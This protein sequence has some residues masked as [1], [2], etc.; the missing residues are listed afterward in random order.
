MALN[1][2]TLPCFVSTPGSLFVKG[3]NFM[4]MH[5]MRG[6][7][8]MGDKGNHCLS[9]IVYDWSQQDRWLHGY[10]FGC[11]SILLYH[12]IYFKGLFTLSACPHTPGTSTG[13]ALNYL[14]TL[15]KYSRNLYISGLNHDIEYHIFIHIKL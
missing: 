15:I 11:E 5:L 1:Y 4:A 13:H 6:V 2:D 3:H 14:V 10:G 9:I 7:G 8:E 12:T